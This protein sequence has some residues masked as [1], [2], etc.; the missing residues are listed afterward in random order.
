VLFNERDFKFHLDKAVNQA[1]LEYA[2]EEE[3]RAKNAR[4]ITK[5]GRQNGH[6]EWDEQYELNIKHTHRY[7]SRFVDIEIRGST[8]K[9]VIQARGPEKWVLSIIE[10]GESTL[11]AENTDLN[12]LI[13]QTCVMALG[14]A[15]FEPEL[16][17]KPKPAK[18]KAATK[19]RG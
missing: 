15:Y 16:W 8:R 11:A 4:Q 2:A 12:S 13:Q 14:H 1:L 3:Q 10:A 17:E 5:S 18:V 9:Y 6:G 7:G 19:R